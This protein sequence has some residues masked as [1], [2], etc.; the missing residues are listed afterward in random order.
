MREAPAPQVADPA[1]ELPRR[2]L[3]AEVH[4]VDRWERL[5][6]RRRLER[7]VARGA[8]KDE[9]GCEGP[10]HCAEVKR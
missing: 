7:A 9:C 6:A 4:R 8:V 10:C 3:S 1:A 2:A 5:R